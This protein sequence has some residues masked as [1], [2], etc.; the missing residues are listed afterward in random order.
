M[1]GKGL[2]LKKKGRRP[3][4]KKV[5]DFYFYYY[6]FYYSRSEAVVCSLCDGVMGPQSCSQGPGT[7]YG[8]QQAEREK[9]T[10]R[11]NER[12]YC[13]LCSSR[14][15]F[16][17]LSSRVRPEI[18]DPPSLATA[19]NFKNFKPAS[20]Q[21]S[22]RRQ[23]PNTMSLIIESGQGIQVLRRSSLAWKRYPPHCKSLNGAG[24]R[25]T[26]EDSPWQT[27]LVG[28]SMYL[29]SGLPYQVCY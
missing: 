16:A 20:S 17:V 5:I 2:C 27:A 13:R 25:S 21:E 6:Y 7:R 29:A 23:T 28:R 26:H 4:K 15:R 18:L 11:E 19:A 22:G 12:V 9:K 1:T 24:P 3:E 10:D 14:Q 8:Y